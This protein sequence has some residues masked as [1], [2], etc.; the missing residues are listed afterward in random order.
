MGDVVAAVE[1]ISDAGFKG[2]VLGELM[3]EPVVISWL[4]LG[5]RESGASATI[6]VLSILSRSGACCRRAG[7]CEEEIAY[8]VM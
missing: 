3:K 1:D 7:R 4:G 2:W 8:L 6:T 5:M